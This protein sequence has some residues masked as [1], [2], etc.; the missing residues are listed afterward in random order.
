[1]KNIQPSLPLRRSLASCEV[2]AVRLWQSLHAI[3]REYEINKLALLFA[4]IFVTGCASSPVANDRLAHFDGTTGYRIDNIPPAN[5]NS[6]GLFVVLTFSGGGTRAAAFSYGALETL[7]DTEIVWKGERRKL[8]DEVDVI[9]AV[10]GGSV[11]AAYY[12]LYGD[13]IFEDFKD[14][15]LYANFQKSFLSQMFSWSTYFRLSTP[16]YTRM[17]V[18][19][20]TMSEDVFDRQ[21]FGDLLRR[22]QR[23]FII[24]NATDIALGS[25][26]GFTQNDFDHLYSDLSTFE[27][28][29]AV[30]AS[31]AVPGVVTPMILQNFERGADYVMPP[32][33]AQAIERRDVSSVSYKQARTLERYGE[34]ERRYVH[35]S[36]GG[37]S[38]NLGLLP[39]IQGLLQAEEPLESP[40][41]DTIDQT[42]RV[43]IITVNAKGDAAR[44]WQYKERPPSLLNTIFAASTAPLGNHTDTEIMYMQLLVNSLKRDAQDGDFNGPIDFEFIE[45]SFDHIED[46]TQRDRLKSLPTSLKLPDEDVDLLRQSAREILNEHPVFQRLL[47]TLR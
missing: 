32:W 23:P 47:K 1:M 14:R 4:I 22:E 34:A 30:A 19:A 33:A 27:V 18:I 43:I 9:S 46:A 2:D 10:S 35:L 41:R 38:D 8:L 37:L 45:I 26:F 11:T 24:I 28:G 25:R 20:E 42:E 31:A 12:G 36:D 3:S 6:N 29:H 16:S 21:T 13:H 17:N 7:R 39:I 40:M 44:P 5:D 15:V